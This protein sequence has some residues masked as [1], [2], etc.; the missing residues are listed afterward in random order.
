MPLWQRLLI[1]LATMLLSSLA[2]GLL[3]RWLFNTDITSYLSRVVGGVTA[4]PMWELLKR[5][6]I[7]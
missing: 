6:E 2:A 5:I 7:R 4:V 3:W 1:T